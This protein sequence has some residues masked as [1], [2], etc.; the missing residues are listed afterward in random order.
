MMLSISSEVTLAP[1]TLSVPT[2]CPFTIVWPMRIR[3][4]SPIYFSP[5]RSVRAVLTEMALKLWAAIFLSCST[6]ISAILPP[7]CP[8]PMKNTRIK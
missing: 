8:N 5:I 1:V 3:S 2:P 6:N 7:A 4:R